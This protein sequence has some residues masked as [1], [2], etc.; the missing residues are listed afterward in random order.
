MPLAARNAAAQKAPQ[1]IGD[2][3]AERI[4]LRRDQAPRLVDP[5]LLRQ[6]QERVPA[7]GWRPRAPRR[8]P[9]PAGSAWAAR[10]R[11]RVVAAR[12]RAAAHRS[13]AP[14]M[15]APSRPPGVPAGVRRVTQAPCRQPGGRLSSGPRRRGRASSRAPVQHQSSPGP[16]GVPWAALRRPRRRRFVSRCEAAAPGQA[17]HHVPL[18][19][20]RRR[21][22]CWRSAG[23]GRSGPPGFRPSNTRAS[24]QAPI[25]ATLGAG[26]ERPVAGKDATV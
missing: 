7:R 15:H 10:P 4:V 18:G 17:R 2:L 16:C 8:R 13:R 6:M 20:L 14:C 11:R 3:D 19:G 23:N 22:H 24:F 25:L 21:R 1:P 5:R 12:G 9:P 26:T